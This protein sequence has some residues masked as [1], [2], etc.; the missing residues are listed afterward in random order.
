MAGAE[1]R[2]Y[3][4]DVTEF[5]DIMGASGGAY[6]FHR[7]AGSQTPPPGAGNFVYLD[8]SGASPRV[9]CCGTAITLVQAESARGQAL[10]HGARDLYVRL[11]IARATRDAE[12][13]DIVQAHRP[14]IVAALQD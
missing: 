1:G 4:R 3:L 8:T 14:V 7:I 9:V 5:I 10:A 12:H 6:R 11:N 13:D 2:R